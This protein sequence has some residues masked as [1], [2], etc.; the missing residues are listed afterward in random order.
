VPVARKLPEILNPS[1]F[2]PDS[3]SDSS[4]LPS[5]SP[6]IRAEL[7]YETR[8]ERLRATMWSRP[9]RATRS[10][11]CGSYSVDLARLRVPA[12]PV[13]SSSSRR[14]L[15]LRSF[16][17][18][19][20]TYSPRACAARPSAIR[21]HTPPGKRAHGAGASRYAGSRSRRSNSSSLSPSPR[22]AGT[23]VI[24]PPPRSPRD[25]STGLGRSGLIQ[26]SDCRRGHAPRRPARARPASPGD[27]DGRR[28]TSCARIR[29]R[30][31]PREF[32]F[33]LGRGVDLAGPRL[34]R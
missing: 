16:S 22:S 2:G 34:L 7:P 28:A 29:S 32:C 15:S 14:R 25:L 18:R 30:P 11:S 13:A 3:V 31:T 23:S 27:A 26:A 21:H 20:S 4:G 1:K 6:T 10:G 9:T 24:A 17:I 12:R 8:Q 5:S 33:L 19:C